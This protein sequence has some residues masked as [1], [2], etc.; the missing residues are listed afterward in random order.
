MEKPFKMYDTLLSSAVDVYKIGQPDRYG[1]HA[2]I[3]YS[4]DGKAFKDVPELSSIT[5]PAWLTTNITRLV[6]IQST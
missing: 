5:G 4:G 6:P 3:Y 1:A 2:L